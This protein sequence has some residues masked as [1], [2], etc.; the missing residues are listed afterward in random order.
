MMSLFQ[1][2]SLSGGVYQGRIPFSGPHSLFGP[3]QKAPTTLQK[4][5]TQIISGQKNSEQ[6]ENLSRT[7]QIRK[8]TYVPKDSS[9]SDPLD[10]VSAGLLIGML[11]IM[12]TPRYRQELSDFKEQLQKMDNT[13]QGYQDILD[14]KTPLQEGQDMESVDFSCMLAKAER[15]RFFEF[16]MT[17][18]GK[19]ESFSDDWYEKTITALL[20]E[21]RFAQKTAY[22]CAINP[23]ASDIYSE[24]DRVLAYIDGRTEE[25]NQGISRLYGI[26]YKRG[27]GEK[28][29][30]YFNHEAAPAEP[31]F[32]AR[33]IASW[34]R[35][36]EQLNA[37]LQEVVEKPVQES[38]RKLQV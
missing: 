35:E 28:Y 29:K 32:I 8:D 36:I 7:A 15:K 26:L 34:K 10:D 1:S 4:L 9:D 37:D 30:S 17:F 5:S 12:L 19:A 31:S 14:G 6:L 3:D 25:T 16:G 11:Q 18:L 13:I 33:R 22:D 2:V 21:C 24:I 20:G 27:C 38:V 23:N